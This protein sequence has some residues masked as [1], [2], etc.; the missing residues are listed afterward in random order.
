MIE[1]QRFRTVSSTTLVIAALIL[2]GCERA[3]T[4]SAS[5]AGASSTP[6]ASAAASGVAGPGDTSGGNVPI[7]TAQRHDSA[8]APTDKWL[9][10]WT[11]PEGT[12]LTLSGGNGKYRVTIRNL[13][14]PRTFDGLANGN[15]IDFTRDGKRESIHATNGKETGM[16]WLADKTD[17]LTVH[18]GEGYCRS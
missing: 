7:D 16:K 11:G 8:A 5:G 6:R 1:F 4:P 15:E 18:P 9:G 2:P 17:C 12:A 14:G 3:N 10:T 13:D